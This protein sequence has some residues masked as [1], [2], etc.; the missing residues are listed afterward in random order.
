MICLNK[1]VN[2][3]KHYLVI[4]MLISISMHIMIFNIWESLIKI[5]WALWTLSI[6]KTFELNQI[7]YRLE[8]QD[9][10]LSVKPGVSSDHIRV[11]LQKNN[12]LTKAKQTKK[13]AQN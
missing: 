3:V 4:L 6:Y 1:Y 8:I 10:Y 13:S 12:K 7:I 5:R 9:W 2:K 11:L